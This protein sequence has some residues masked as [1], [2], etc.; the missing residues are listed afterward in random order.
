MD[1]K[2][3]D[4]FI[5][6]REDDLMNFY[7]PKRW[8][9]FPRHFLAVMSS[10][11]AILLSY[12]I[13]HADTH[14][15]KQNE[16]WFYCLK[17]LIAEEIFFNFDKQTILFASLE[18]RDFIETKWKGQPALRWIKID[19]KAIHKK[20]AEVTEKLE[21]LA[22]KGKV[23]YIKGMKDY[24]DQQLTKSPKKEKEPEDNITLRVRG[25]PEPR[26]RDITEPQGPGKTGAWLPGKTGA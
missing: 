19:G 14:A 17:Q 25:K 10:D 21:D 24:L 26:I 22:A 9:Q 8:Y 1:S 4:K 16:G 23:D 20:T 2:K 11:E 5:S 3:Q 7:S 15:T 12:L 13:N 6:I 18:R